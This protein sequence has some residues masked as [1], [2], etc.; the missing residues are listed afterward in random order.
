MAITGISTAIIDIRA[1]DHISG[2]LSG[3]AAKIAMVGR[4][5]SSAGLAMTATFSIP[6]AYG[7]VKATGA[8][9]EFDKSL[10]NIQAI[11]KQTDAEINALSQR[12]MGLSTDITK[13][14]AT[15]KY[16]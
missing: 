3:M 4:A 8:A 12:M 7:I 11:G 5:I 13:T 14:I 16:K 10:R 9:V 1:V 15:N 2:Q 6:L